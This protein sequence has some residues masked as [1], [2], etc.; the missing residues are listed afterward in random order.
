MSMYTRRLTSRK[1]RFESLEKRALLT[2]ALDPLLVETSDGDAPALIAPMADDGQMHHDP[3]SSQYVA[4]HHEPYL[5]NFSQLPA[6]AGRNV[7]HSTGDGDWQTLFAT[8]GPADVVVVDHAIHFDGAADVHSIVIRDGGTLQFDV[9]GEQSLRVVNF[10]VL[11]GGTLEIGTA[12][13]PHQG[14]AEIVFKDAPFDFAVDPGQYGHGLVALGTVTMHGRTLQQTF[15]TLGSEIRA[16]DD[17][18]TFDGDLSGWSVGDRLLIPD[19]RQLFYTDNVTTKLNRYESPT[20][21]TIESGRLRLQQAAQYDHLG[22]RDAAGKLAFLPHVA[23]LSRNVVLRSENPAGVRGH[24]MLIGRAEI[25]IRYV[26]FRD[27]GRTTNA[28]VNNTL[29][30]DGGHAYQI[31]TNQESRYPIHLHHLIG[32]REIPANGHQYTIQGNSVHSSVSNL[33]WGITIH[34]SHYGLVD[35]NVV[36]NFAGAGIVTENGSESYNTISNNFVSRISGTG[37]RGKFSIGRE[38]DGIWLKR[39]NNYVDGNV[40]SGAQ[41]AAYG[42][43]G[44]DNT[45]MPAERIPAFQ[46]ADTHMGEYVLLNPDQMHLLSFDSNVG[47]ASMNGLDLWYLGFQ[48]YYE[49]SS[50]AVA[51]T[52]INDLSLWNINHTAVFGEQA[53]NVTFRRMTV[54]GSTSVASRYNYPTGVSVLRAKDV[55]IV[56]SAIENLRNGIITPRRIDRLDT[57]LKFGDVKPFLVKN[58]RLSND[59]NVIVGTPVEDASGRAPAKH[60]VIDNVIF[61]SNPVFTSAG[62]STDIRM[63]YASGRFANVIQD[64][65]VEVLN[66]NGTPGEDFRVYYPQQAPSYVVPMTGE[67]STSPMSPW[68][69]PVAGLTNEESWE[70][71]GIAIAGSVAPGDADS[72]YRLPYPAID[73]LVFPLVT[74]TIRPKILVVTPD[75]GTRGDAV[76]AAN[77]VELKGVAPALSTVDLYRDGAFV[78]QAAA[79]ANGFWALDLT[80][81]A[82]ADGTYRFTV[83]AAGGQ[84][85][86]QIFDVQVLS[87]APILSGESVAIPEDTANGAV[88]TTINSD[89]DVVFSIISGDPEA[90][91]AID[92]ASGDV[93]LRNGTSLGTRV[94]TELVLTVQAVNRAGLASNHE[95]KIEIIARPP[96]YW[97]THLGYKSLGSLTAEEMSFVTPRQ[98]GSIPDAYWF[99]TIPA[100]VRATLRAD[101]LAELQVSRSG[102][103]P[104]L[105]QQQKLGLLPEQYQSLGQTEFRH[106]PLERINWLSTAQ[107]GILTDKMWFSRIPS[108]VRAAIEPERLAQLPVELSGIYSLLTA[109]QR[110]ELPDSAYQRLGYREFANVPME[111]IPSLS[112]AQ[113]AA[114]P[115]RF[116]FSII[117]SANRAEFTE[118]QVL[119]LNLGL[120]TVSLLTETQREWISDEQLAQVHYRDFNVLSVQQVVKLSRAQLTSIPDSWWFNRISTAGREALLELGIYWNGGVVFPE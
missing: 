14:T 48:T 50:L 18:V 21:A 31:G 106:V 88:V 100:A 33:K 54:I 19:S 114:I 37:G 68:G 12:T 45:R 10:Q 42:I 102:M 65:V 77:R 6:T 67:H 22:A 94:G 89:S 109:Q 3:Q 90:I 4:N 95:F 97:V 63:S 92:A 23:N 15:T 118:S 104:L 24:T 91:F 86:E 43:Y 83:A 40:V 28:A 103:L 62:F 72:D 41:R 55:Q 38:G 25:D 44:G 16:G 30:H 79:D 29:F 75:T 27:L 5:P 116:W 8:A 71:Y 20:L 82:L 76:T 101:Q 39:P 52:D 59:V 84:S 105:T 34:G 117:P 96:G 87:T 119:H 120:G 13:A 110:L 115:D 74:G 93:L 7:F 81:V 46:G 17:F 2:A 51:A 9:A 107:F 66:Y 111:R 36:Y 49:P 73:G 56:D 70:Q 69:A 11:E 32:P 78:G 35:Q 57:S 1:L 61:E 58:T 113:I 64:D 112:G 85:T 53:N 98:I 99:G 80:S 47:Y 60:I 108:E 26:E